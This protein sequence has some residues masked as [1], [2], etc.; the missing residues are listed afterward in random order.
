MDHVLVFPCKV[1]CIENLKVFEILHFILHDIWNHGSNFV[2]DS[3]NIFN[4]TFKYSQIMI[5]FHV[6][7][8]SYESKYVSLGIGTV[9]P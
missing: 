7:L 1:N 9:K 2:N 5:K 6:L 8:F 3:V 4:L